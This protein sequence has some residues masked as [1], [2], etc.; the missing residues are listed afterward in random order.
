MLTDVN[1]A[2]ELVITIAPPSGLRSSAGSAA[3]MVKYT[4]L[5]ITATASVNA[6]MSRPCGPATGRMPALASTKSRRPS[7][8]TPRATTSASR[9]RSRTSPRSATIRRPVFSTSRTVSSRS[10]GVAIG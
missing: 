10:S 3:S 8:A 7:S 2:A 1:P 5:S 4:P 9:S 6:E